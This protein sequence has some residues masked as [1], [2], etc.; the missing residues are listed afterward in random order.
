[1]T[2]SISTV[3]FRYHVSL[4][5][6]SNSELGK[7]LSLQRVCRCQT[8]IFVDGVLRFIGYIVRISDQG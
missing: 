6:Y 7:P 1:M 3:E 8:R 4:C 2:F 5:Y